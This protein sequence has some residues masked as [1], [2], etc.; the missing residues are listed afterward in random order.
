M[1]GYERL[2]FLQTNKFS[3]QHLELDERYVRSVLDKSGMGQANSA[4]TPGSKEAMTTTGSAG[5]NFLDT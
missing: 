2:T 4:V 3:R 5:K 1:L